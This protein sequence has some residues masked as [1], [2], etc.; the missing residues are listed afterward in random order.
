MAHKTPIIATTRGGMAEYVRR[1]R[2][3]MLAEP[4]NVQKLAG[5]ISWLLG[6]KEVWH[7][8]SQQAYDFSDK[9]TRWDVVAYRIRDA[10]D[11][12]QNKEPVPAD[13][14]ISEQISRV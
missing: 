6:E 7:S 4:G 2:F 5:S 13:Y 11:K 14:T 8:R 10:V 3:G 9:N 12:W 1:K